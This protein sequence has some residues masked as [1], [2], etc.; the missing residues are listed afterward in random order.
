M[1]RV[2]DYLAVHCYKYAPEQFQAFRV[3]GFSNGN[4][5]VP[6][7]EKIAL[8]YEDISI[9]GNAYCTKG[10]DAAIAELKRVLRKMERKP[11]LYV[12]IGFKSKVYPRQYRFTQD[13]RC[14]PDDRDG[15]LHIYKEFKDFVLSKN[16]MFEEYTQGN[17]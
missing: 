14:L 5:N 4:R 12:T 17:S 9:C 15:K 1:R 11:V 3:T 2:D 13:L 7:Y 6:I 8:S 10:R 16:C